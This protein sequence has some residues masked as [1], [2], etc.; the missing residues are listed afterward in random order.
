VI[1]DQA[2]LAAFGRVRSFQKAAS[3]KNEPGAFSSLTT[4]RI[5]PKQCS[6]KFKKALPAEE[7][8]ITK[9]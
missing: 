7:A 5:G 9:S 8:G 4:N 2:G 3:K 6:W 1:A